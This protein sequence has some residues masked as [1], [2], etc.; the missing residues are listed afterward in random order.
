MRLCRCCL[1]L[2]APPSAPALAAVDARSTAPRLPARPGAPH[3][4]ELP[5][6]PPCLSRSSERLRSYVNLVG[7][8]GG[9][10]AYMRTFDR[11]HN[12]MGA[13]VFRGAFPRPARRAP[14]GV[15]PGLRRRASPHAARPPPP[16]SLPPPADGRPKAKIRMKKL[17]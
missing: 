15:P 5:R 14:G 7:L 3:L 9:I 6:E 8:K 12:P 13:C 17:M 1:L 4:P 16:W 10:N 11:R 2:P